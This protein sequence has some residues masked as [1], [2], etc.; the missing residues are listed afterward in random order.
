MNH[1]KI[2]D[3]TVAMEGTG[4]TLQRLMKPYRV[5]TKGKS[6]ITMSIH[7]ERMN[8][9]G[10]EYPHLSPDEW[11]YIQTGY[12]FAC[13][14]LDFDGFSLHASA[15]ALDG[16]AVLFSGPCGTGKST[17]TELW[18][19]YFGGDRAVIINDDKPA[20]RLAKDIF[21]AYGTPWS[22]KSALNTNIRVPLCAVVF[23]KQA[24]GNKI[25]RLSNKEAV[26]LLIYQSQR[27]GSDRDRLNRLLILLDALLQKT[28]V[29]QMECT[30]SF[31]AV[32]MVYHEIFQ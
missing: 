11:E 6:D 2:A 17:H 24:K 3:L 25:R 21:Y 8:K 30:I 9:T 19:Q 14:L 7:R 28:P 20:L 32:R 5:V 26:Q 16:R 12:A 29:Y 1:Y 22:G 31:D 18:R 23:L 4:E 13:R 10:E 27:P 15:V